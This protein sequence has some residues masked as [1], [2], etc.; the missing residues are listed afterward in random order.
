MVKK[1]EKK[2]PPARQHE[3]SVN[4]KTLDV[5]LKNKASLYYRMQSKQR[6]FLPSIKS[7]IVTWEYLLFVRNNNYADVD[8]MYKFACPKYCDVRLLPCAIP[9]TL[10]EILEELRKEGAKKGLDFGIDEK[11]TPEKAWALA[12]LSTLN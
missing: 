9:P 5:V 12:V 10:A 2:K 3:R 6:W 8:P 7:S 4:A 11:H 1:V